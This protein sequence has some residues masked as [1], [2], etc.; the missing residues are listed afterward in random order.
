MKSFA[1]KLNILPTRHYTRG[2]HME[3]L[4]SPCRLLGL[5]PTKLELKMNGKN[6]TEK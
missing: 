2:C 6:R 1:V 3:N 5:K 4:I